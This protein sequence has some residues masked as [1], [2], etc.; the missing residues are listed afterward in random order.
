MLFF[1]LWVAVPCPADFI[2]DALLEHFFKSVGV[3]DT[4]FRFVSA[5]CLLPSAPFMATW[6]ALSVPDSLRFR[7]CILLIYR[8]PVLSFWLSVR[9]WWSSCV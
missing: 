8:G 6:F 7:L 5:E 4:L 2:D 9:S 1:T 3:F